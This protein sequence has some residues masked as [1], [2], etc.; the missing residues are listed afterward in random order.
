MLYLPETWA[1]DAAR[2]ADAGVPESMSF[3]TEPKLGQAMLKRALA[4]SVPCR[5]TVGHYMYDAD[6]RTRRLIQTY[7]R[8]YVLAVTLAQRRGRGLA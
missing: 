8:G 7:G 4:A 1:G 6:H 3:I 2:R 5:W